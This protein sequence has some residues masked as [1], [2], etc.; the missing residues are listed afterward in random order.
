MPQWLGSLG[1]HIG[2]GIVVTKLLAVERTFA[3][4]IVLAGVLVAKEE[5]AKP[6]KAR[7]I[8]TARTKVDFMG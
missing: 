8:T 3:E 5:A 6:A 2:T 1:T 4:E 7:V